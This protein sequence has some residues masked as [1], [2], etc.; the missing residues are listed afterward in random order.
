MAEDLLPAGV[1]AEPTGQTGYR[2]ERAVP[3]RSCLCSWPTP[4]ATGDDVRAGVSRSLRRDIVVAVEPTPPSM[5][6]CR[7]AAA[8]HVPKQQTTPLSNRA[9]L[10]LPSPST[11]H[12]RFPEL[13]LFRPK[14][15]QWIHASSATNLSLHVQKTPRGGSH[16][17]RPE[18]NPS[19]VAHVT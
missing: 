11:V 17:R 9:M 13:S 12:W 4:A 1:H 5:V 2:P 10:I 14:R 18:L 15:G 7:G 8:V 16:R 19:C 3:Y 6:T